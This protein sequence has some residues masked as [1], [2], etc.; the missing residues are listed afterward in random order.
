MKT[1]ICKNCSASY[2]PE[3][4]E[5]ED[6]QLCNKCLAKFL[7]YKQTLEDMKRKE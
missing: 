7:V 3:D 5:Q 4:Q 2:V 6:M 1:L